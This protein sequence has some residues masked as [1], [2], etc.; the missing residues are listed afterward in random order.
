MKSIGNKNWWFLTLN[1]ILF[2]I[3]GLFII[4]NPKGFLE[5]L[6]RFFGIIVLIAG[7]A[8]AV[9]GGISTE[10]HPRNWILILTGILDAVL[11]I[12]IIAF[13]K[14][15]FQIIMRLIGIWAVLVGIYQV[16]HLTFR[17]GEIS[18]KSFYL[19]SSL[20][21]IILGCLLIFIPLPA[22]IAVVIIIGLCSLIAGIL[23]TI[24]SFRIR[25]EGAGQAGQD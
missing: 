3:L 14:T 12:L 11:G 8:L 17:T 7:V 16:F 22:G 2:I 9:I 25:K 21:A 13:P 15:T 4:F 18:D 1:G 24:V 10:K 20:F 6:M 23:M 5:G 19:I